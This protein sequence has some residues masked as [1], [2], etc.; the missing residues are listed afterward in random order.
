MTLPFDYNATL[1]LNHS[2]GDIGLYQAMSGRPSDEVLRETDLLA[3]YNGALAEQFVA[4]ELM[5]LLGGSE[6]HWWKRDEK[7]A[8]AEV[9]FM[10]ALGGRVL[11]IEVKSGAAGR[12]KSVNGKVWMCLFVGHIVVEVSEICTLWR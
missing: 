12:L 2:P 4:Q 9:D 7:N 3:T 10:V 11:P 6:P 8:Q 5:A 1:R